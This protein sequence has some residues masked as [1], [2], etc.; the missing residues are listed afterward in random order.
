MACAAA[1]FQVLAQVSFGSLLSD[2]VIA[3]HH[4]LN[5]LNKVSCLSVCLSVTCL[6]VTAVWGGQAKCRPEALHSV[7]QGQAIDRLRVHPTTRTKQPVCRREATTVR[8]R[9]QVHG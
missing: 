1:I 3:K 7:S 9:N 8:Q 6:F 2:I 5:D 4:W